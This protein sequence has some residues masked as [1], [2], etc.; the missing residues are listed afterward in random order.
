MTNYFKD[1]ST[2]D[3][4]KKIYWNLAK[5]FHPDKGGNEEDFKVLNNS[6]HAFKPL[7]EKFQNEAEQWNSKAYANILNELIKLEGVIIDVIGSF[8][9]L[10]GNTKKHKE[11]IKAIDTQDLYNCRWH[12]NKEMWYFAPI[13]YRKSSKRDLTLEQIKDFYGGT[14]VKA[15]EEEE[16]KNK[17]PKSRKIKSATKKLARA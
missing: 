14:T 16:K 2:L 4:A 8:L 9:W 10:S 6:F 12:K 5:Q 13:G 15:N 3:E 11:A 7:T 17:K 1:C